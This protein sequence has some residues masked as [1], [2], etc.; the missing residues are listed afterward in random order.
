[1]CSI[2]SKATQP[3]EFIKLNVIQK[4]A[5]KDY[6]DFSKLVGSIVNNMERIS[7]RKRNTINSSLF[8]VF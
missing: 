1:M 4:L 3:I 5:Y 6:V 7:T 2:F 8:K